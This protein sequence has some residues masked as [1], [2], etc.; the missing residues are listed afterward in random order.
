MEDCLDV[1]VKVVGMGESEFLPERR[2]EGSSGW[3]LRAAVHVEVVIHP[4]E[5]A[6]VPT[7]IALSIPRGTEGQVRPRS[8][9]AAD[10]G[11]TIVNT[12]GTIDSDYRGEIKVILINLGK[13]KYTVK[14]GDRVAQIVFAKVQE[15][16]VNPVTD[17]DSTKRGSGGFG[18]TGT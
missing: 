14:R 16:S 6:I 11:L 4:L 13:E 9:L 8:G 7:G 1:L 12:P 3:D 15:V 17:L 5:R 18:S 2:T 10:Y